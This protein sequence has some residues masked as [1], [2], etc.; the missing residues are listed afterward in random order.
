[1]ADPDQERLRDFSGGCRTGPFRLNAAA[2][3]RDGHTETLLKEDLRQDPQIGRDLVLPWACAH[4]QWPCE[5]R[6]KKDRV[7]L[8]GLWDTTQHG[9]HA[10]DHTE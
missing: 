4:V 5:Q 7:M 1:M 6:T 3:H 2:W 8:K 10:G 9:W